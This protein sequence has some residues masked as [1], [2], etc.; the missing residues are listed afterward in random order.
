MKK[1]LLFVSLCLLGSARGASGQPDEPPGSMSHQASVQQFS[2]QYFSP[3]NPSDA[4]ALYEFS[5][6]EHASGEQPSSEQPAGE[7]LS[8]EQP[9]GEQP[10]GE[11]PLDE[12]SLGEQ[13][14]GEQPAGEEDPGEKPV[15]E[16][17]SGSPPSST[18][19]GPVFNC[20]TCSYMNN[21]GKCLHGEGVCSTQNSQQCMLKK[22]FKD[23][24]LQYMVQGCKNKCS[25]MNLFS[26]GI[27]VQITCCRNLSF[28]NK[29]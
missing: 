19:S 18:F 1:L 7:K 26:K 5:S 12:K 27:R 8:V 21:Q 17:L 16:Q 24:K 29:I 4:E 2:G 20:H 23:G 28:C 10:S 11:K 6:G 3:A 25:S 13:P 15:S 22:I 9:A 14:S